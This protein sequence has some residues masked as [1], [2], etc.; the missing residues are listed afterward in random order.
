MA[1]RIFTVFLIAF[2]IFLLIVPFVSYKT[3]KSAIKEEMFNHLI[4]TRDILKRQIWGYFRE[5]YGDVDV[6]ARN[7]VVAEGFTQL[8]SAFSAN[9]IE[10]SEFQ[11]VS[12][13]YHPI[14]EHYITDYGYANIY[15]VDKDGNVIFSA[16][17]GEY[18]GT[19][20][21]T[22]KFK[23]S[24]FAHVFMRGLE[25]I[26]FVDYSWHREVNDYTSYCVAPVYESEKLSGVLILE[27]PFSHLDI[28]LTERSGLG[29]TGEM[30][31]VGD[32]GFMRSNSRF[33]E[34]P[35]ILQLEVDTEATREAHEGHVGTKIIKDYRGVPVLS[36]Y[37]PL[38]LNFI[39]WSL[40]V[41][42]D[43]AEAFAPIR[44]V[45]IKLIIIGSIIGTIT[46]G[47]L[48]LAYRR[49]RKHKS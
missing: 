8:S 43:A 45:E 4:T 33:S 31:L 13:I 14:V 26:V 25:D 16:L 44:A 35:T 24:N 38:D 36:A 37:T 2:L 40:F 18:F 39:N 29:Q 46:I 49:G 28:I 11:R 6:L 1:K 27:N 23:Q 42:I 15:F 47:Y 34:K 3:L 41:E 17:K 48:Y 20:L 9:G 10:S 19:N 7:P 12:N 21:F 30:Y 22:G 5:V 32:D